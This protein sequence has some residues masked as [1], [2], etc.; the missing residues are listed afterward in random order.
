MAA[1]NSPS[2]SVNSI[3]GGNKTAARCAAVSVSSLL[4]LPVTCVQPSK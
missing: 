3:T 2:Y 4:L 1:G